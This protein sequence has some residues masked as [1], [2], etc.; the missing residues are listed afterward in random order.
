MELQ[1]RPDWLI[2][3]Y[4]PIFD[5]TKRC[6][7][8]YGGRDSGKSYAAAQLVVKWLLAEESVRVVLLR[9]IYRDVKDSQFQTIVDVIEANGLSSLFKITTSPLKI[10]CLHNKNSLIARG[11]DKSAKM[12]S[13]ANPTKIWYEEADEIGLTDFLKSGQSLR[14]G[15]EAVLQ[16]LITFNPENEEENFISSVFF[17]AKSSYEKSDGQFSLVESRRSDALIIHSTYKDNPYCTPDRGENLESLATYA[18]DLYRI[19][20]LGLWGGALKGLIY[21]EF[22]TCKVFPEGCKWIVYGLDFGF[23]NDPT[24]LIKV[25][26]YA[27]K[28]YFQELL[29]ITGQTNQDLNNRFREMGLKY[30]DE[31]VADSADPKSIEELKRMHWNI[32]PAEKGPD[33]VRNGI[34]VIKRYPL[35][36]TEDSVNL[37]KE[38]RSYKWKENKYIPEDSPG[39]F[40][41]VPIDLWNH[42]WDAIRYGVTYKI[43]APTGK[44][45]VP[46]LPRRLPGRDNF[47]DQFK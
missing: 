3:V 43:K 14:A 24:A 37:L 5:S 31:I 9:K 15:P 45:A 26:F 1:I 33:S 2:P 34:G 29:Y 47:L 10:V 38:R 20:V 46:R 16:E 27:G 22:T 42:A 4:R 32:I 19:Y 6:I 41:N 18:P 13:I 28:L 7:V 21:D 40:L 30:S 25:G 17:P 12:K 44:G 8:L 39:H 35:V 11:L 23:T 36:I